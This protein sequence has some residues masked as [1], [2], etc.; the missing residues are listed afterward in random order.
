MERAP[1]Q[2]RSSSES[3]ADGSSRC[4]T[5]TANSALATALIVHGTL[6]GCA[7]PPQARDDRS[8]AVKLTAA[9]INAGETGRAI[10]VPL[11][12]RTQVTVIVSG[13]PPELASR[14]VH[15]HSFV[16]RGSC[17]SLAAEP[18]YALTERVLAQ[19]ATPGA[20][21]GPLTVTNMAPVSI[22]RLMGEPYAIRVTTA[23]ADGGREI[24]CGDIR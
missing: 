5:R 20:P 19:A 7:S 23:P 2:A 12:D 1:D 10:L 14:P 24:F 21:L 18:S 3:S 17:G 16:Y 9:P 4:R 11:G 15:L 22:D 13:V 8:I 6:W